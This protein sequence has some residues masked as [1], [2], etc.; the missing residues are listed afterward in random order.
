MASGGAGVG[1]IEYAH[2]SNYLSTQ[3]YRAFMNS[4]D[5]SLKGRDHYTKEDDIQIKGAI[6]KALDASPVGARGVADEFV[7]LHGEECINPAIKEL[8]LRE[9]QQTGARL[10]I[11][12]GSPDYLLEA[13]GSVFPEGTKLIGAPWHSP[14][15]DVGKLINLEKAGIDLTEVALAASDSINDLPLMKLGAKTGRAWVVSRSESDE[16]LIRW[17]V[18]QNAKTQNVFLVDHNSGRVSSF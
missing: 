12:S 11:A 5:I 8:A 6:F 13:F 7:A 18:E 4:Y 10:V 15:F 14:G 17:G 16:K 3:I 2:R 9:L 1:F